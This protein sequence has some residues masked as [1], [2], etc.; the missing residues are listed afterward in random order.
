[1]LRPRL[2]PALLI[3]NGALVKT[4][5]FKSKRYLGDPINAVR[6]FNEKQADEVVILDISA[7]TLGLEPDY[8]LIKS[9]SCECRV[10]LAYGGGITSIEQ[11]QRIVNLGVE[12][13]ILSSSAII[14]PTIISHM[15]CTLGSQSITVALDIRQSKGP[16][17]KTTYQ[18]YSHNGT[19]RHN[20]DIV[21]LCK[22]L[23]KAGAG[24]LLI[25]SIDQDGLMNGYDL[26]LASLIAECVS[27]PLTFLGG[28]QTF[29]DI[30][31]LVQIHGNIGAA[32][33]SLFVFKG[34]LKAVLINYPDFAQKM[35]I[36]R[37]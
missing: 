27:V 3:D 33:G 13:V 24:E 8:E 1:M 35:S 36:L 14:D 37:P 2:I 10:P 23:V 29:A 21:E 6:I 28:A 17:S 32:A 26:K 20:H 30:T 19:K 16:F 12:K 31:E 15:A 9:L 5:N 7:T 34:K 18:V 22:A 4:V 11:A 25:N